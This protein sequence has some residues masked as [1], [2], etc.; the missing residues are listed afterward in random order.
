MDA[1]D[2]FILETLSFY[3]PMLKENLILKLDKYKLENFKDFSLEELDSR[4]KRLLKRGFL[5]KSGRG[6]DRLFLR[7]LPSSLPWYKKLLNKYF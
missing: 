2:E 1:L 5:K 6:N 7:I 4:L 3:T